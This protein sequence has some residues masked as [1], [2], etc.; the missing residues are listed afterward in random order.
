MV[1]NNKARVNPN[2]FLSFFILPPFLIS[3]SRRVFGQLDLSGLMAFL[4]MKSRHGNGS[5]S[6]DGKFG[7]TIGPAKPV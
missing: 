2:I 3:N 7:T 6:E 4:G 1:I 5:I